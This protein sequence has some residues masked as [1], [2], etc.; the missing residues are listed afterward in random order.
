MGCVELNY[1]R[2]LGLSYQKPIDI[3]SH[4]G[5]KAAK[6]AQD[7][8]IGMDATNKLGISEIVAG[9][10]D[11]VSAYVSH[12]TVKASELPDLISSVY[13]ALTGL[14][15]P[16]AAAVEPP[17]PAVP[18]KKSITDDYLISLEDGKRYKSLKR[19][20]S[21][22]G[23]TPAQYREKWGLKADY[24][25]VAPSYSKQRSELAKT[26]G[27]GQSRAKA[28]APEV[29]A[30]PLSRSGGAARRRPRS[31]SRPPPI[32]SPAV[33]APGVR[34]SSLPIPA[35]GIA[36]WCEWYAQAAPSRS[37]CVGHA[38]WRIPSASNPSRVARPGSYASAPT[39]RRR[40]ANGSSARLVGGRRTGSGQASRGRGA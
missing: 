7:I 18:V 21:G 8:G 4:T 11:V 17:T 9:T 23:L 33:R 24:P 26:A 2:G 40:V 29:V 22:R 15:T 25:M 39:E 38:G 30:A 19:H 3:Y 5:P 37:L 27:L 36:E 16:R 1:S 6:G 28:V 35:R 20:L 31:G 12:N 10:A 34:F 14:S 32:S 13:A